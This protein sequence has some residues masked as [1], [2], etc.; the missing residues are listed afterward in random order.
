MGSGQ[1]CFVECC[2]HMDINCTGNK[3]LLAA[4]LKQTNQAT[5]LFEAKSL[6]T[7]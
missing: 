5:K 3:K 1:E 7:S 4:Q 2:F 6:S